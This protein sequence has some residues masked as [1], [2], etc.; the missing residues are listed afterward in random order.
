M[1]CLPVFPF[2]GRPWSM[3]CSV[4]AWNQLTAPV[5]SGHCGWALR[6]WLLLSSEPLP[7]CHYCPLWQGFKFIH[8][9]SWSSGGNG[10]MHLVIRIR[11][12]LFSHSF[13]TLLCLTNPEDIN[14]SACFEVEKHTFIKTT[15]S[16]L[17]WVTWVKMLETF[18]V[19][20]I[21]VFLFFSVLLNHGVWIGD[22][23]VCTKGSELFSPETFG[24]LIIYAS[25]FFFMDFPWAV[26][27]NIPIESTEVLICFNDL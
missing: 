12:K 3:G 25:R 6:C 15:C 11:G 8:E 21:L 24:N 22:L 10:E 17:D 13:A 7:S 9:T 16:G 19:D 4:Y 18:Q 2:P 23:L 5:L 14:C 1:P 20:W 27:R 26:F